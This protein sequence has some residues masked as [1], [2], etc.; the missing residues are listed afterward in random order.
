M[1]NISKIISILFLGFSLLLLSYVIYRSE[2]YH[3]GSKS[4]YYLK[5]YIFS[6]SLVVLGIIS[7]FLKEEFKIKTTMVFVSVILGLYLIEIY[8]F[9][10]SRQFR[11]WK[12]GVKY[13]TRTQYE[14]YNDLKKEDDDIVVRVTPSTYAHK[15][16][17]NIFPL[18][19]ISNKKTILCNEHG[20]FPIYDSDRY[21]FNNPDSEWDKEETEYLL[22]GDSYTQGDC[23][24]TE[25]NI[26]GNLRRL[27]GKN[28]INLGYGGNGPLIEYASLREYLPLIKTKRMLWLYC[29]GNDLSYSNIGLEL[30]NKILLKYLE[31]PNFT[32][33]LHLRQDEIDLVAKHELE[34]Q[35]AEK[36]KNLKNTK[37]Y[38][39]KFIKLFN[40]R[41]SILKFTKKPS[42]KKINS[43]FKKIIKLAKDLA[44][45]NN[46]DFYFI[47]VPDNYRYIHKHNFSS[48]YFND[49]NKIINYVS[50]LGIPIIDLH[51]ELLEKNHD[52]K[53][54]RD[55]NYHF[56]EDGYRIISEH[57]FKSILNYENYNG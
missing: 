1:K 20:Y 28:V 47:Y 17:N 22:V 36:K 24:N 35:L 12:S 37:F 9:I 7:F 38:F 3:S 2:F 8:F 18:S 40:V 50:S 55:K 46:I 34:K 13:D 4:D 16:S 52:G 54:R 6:I 5:Y 26:A 33:N 30:K 45:Q 15:N 23:V 48:E 43:E 10:D 27:S 31:Y 11:I 44:D 29:E 41:Y 25:D 53:L 57:I 49:Y 21:G 51:S 32:Q 14:I 56:S 39:L 42:E 19:G